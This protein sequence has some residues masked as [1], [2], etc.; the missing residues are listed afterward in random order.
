MQLEPDTRHPDWSGRVTY[1]PTYKRS[2]IEG[3]AEGAGGFSRQDATVAIRT[4]DGK[5]HRRTGVTIAQAGAVLRSKVLR[6]VSGG[7]GVCVRET[8]K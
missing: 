8:A 4:T 2:L 1:K 3:L 6:R 5:R 7:V